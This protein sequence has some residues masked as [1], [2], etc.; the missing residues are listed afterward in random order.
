MSAEDLLK[1]DLGVL[2]KGLTYDEYHDAPGVRSG[3]LSDIRRSPAHFQAKQ[4]NP[5]DPTEALE[6]GKLFHSAIENGEKFLDMI[7]V[8]PKFTGKTLEGNESGNSKEAKLKRVEWAMN[9]KPGAIVV[10]E[11][12]AKQ[13]TGMMKVISNHSKAK[14]LLKDSIRESSGWVK[15]PITGLILKFRP[16]LISA[17]EYVVDFKTTMDASRQSFYWDVFSLRGRDPRFYILN[18]AHYAYCGKLL[19]LKRHDSFVFVAIE[20]TA[21]WGLNVFGID[22]GQLDI[23]ERW[24]AHLTRQYAECLASGKWPCYAEDVQSFETPMYPDLPEHL[25]EEGEEL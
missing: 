15:D 4:L 10:T 25:W 18:A 8:M 24:R 3:Y 20:K 17:H 23:G 13:L 19:G 7:K 9:L 21:P 14:F 16:D 6:F 5:K 22:K 11:D 2:H 12:Q 1:F